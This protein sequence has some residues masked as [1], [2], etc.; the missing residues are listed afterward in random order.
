MQILLP[1]QMV[2]LPS[3]DCQVVGAETVRRALWLIQRYHFDLVICDLDL[4]Q[5]GGIALLHYVA[6]MAPETMA[7]LLM[8][9]VDQL[10]TRTAFKYGALD[11]YVK[12]LTE[13]T[14]R[15]FLYAVRNG[16]QNQ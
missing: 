12:P 9:Q 4:P 7:I 1:A 5:S 6:L 10:M 3:Q 14:I 8:A 13:A 2:R 15:R 16:S 11:Y